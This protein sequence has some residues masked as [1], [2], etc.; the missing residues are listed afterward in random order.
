MRP[1]SCRAGDLTHGRAAAVNLNTTPVEVVAHIQDV[2][3]ILHLS[4]QQNI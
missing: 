4:R 1:A 3:R 2:V